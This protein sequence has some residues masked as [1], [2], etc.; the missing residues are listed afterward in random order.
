MDAAQISRTSN[1]PSA[2][3]P[4]RKLVPVAFMDAES[5]I[6]F[7]PEDYVDISE[8]WDIKEKMLLQHLSQHMPGP[9]YDSAYTLPA[10]SE[11]LAIVREARVMSEF[12]GLACRVRYAEG[13]RWWR[14]ANR[15]VAKRLLP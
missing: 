14:A 1:Y 10:D 13:F 11:T 7:A 9:K 12:R 15:I 6:N 4:V 3:P 8:V 2:L 5:G